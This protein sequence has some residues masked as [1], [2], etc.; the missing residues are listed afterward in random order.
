VPEATFPTSSKLDFVHL[1]T[2]R[3][4]V[5]SLGRRRFCTSGAKT[6][7]QKVPQARFSACLSMATICLTASG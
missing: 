4:K 3:H 7:V 6:D 2:D 5:D 1:A